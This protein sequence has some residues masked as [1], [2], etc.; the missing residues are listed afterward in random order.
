MLR[1]KIRLKIKTAES[2]VA[3]ELAERITGNKKHDKDTDRRNNEQ[4]AENRINLAD[5]LIYRK[6]RRDKIIN[7]D[8]AVDD[9]GRSLA[10]GPAE[11]E[12]LCSR[13]IARSINKNNAA[14]E[15][16]NAHKSRK[17]PEHAPFL[18]PSDHLGHLQ[19]ALAG[20]YHTGKIIM[21]GTADH[22]AYGNGDKSDRPEK[23]TLNRSE[24]RARSRDVEQ[25]DKTV[26]PALHGNVVNI[27][28][29][30]VSGSLPVIRT[31]N[32]LADSPVNQASDQQYGQTCQKSCHIY[33]SP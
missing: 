31:E 7:K 11:P 32:A 21:H 8:R 25:V 18:E 20:T 16:G 15:A 28:L 17:E 12:Q 23:N 14:Q 4:S 1:R 19:P 22:T 26:L 33:K 24:N 3:P 6:N 2:P 9:P 29:F 13:Y 30:S 5:D 10:R 27:I